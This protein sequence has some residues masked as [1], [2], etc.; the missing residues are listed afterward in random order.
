VEVL[1]DLGE[2]QHRRADPA[3]QDIEGD[4][5]ADRQGAVD[6]EP[7][8]EIE[9]GR[10]HQLVDELNK[11][12]CGVSEAQNLEARRD[13]GGE[14]IL[15]AALHLRLDGHRLERFDAAD[16]LH[17]KRLV[18]GATLECLVEAAFEQRRRQHRNA[19]VE[20]E[21]AEHEERQKR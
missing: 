7:G 5:L 18:L 20:R 13:V 8:A 17:Q 14:L 11:L 21:G 10:G 2:P 12:A 19:D 4:K 1:P 15:P 6:D 3:G 9:H 16:A